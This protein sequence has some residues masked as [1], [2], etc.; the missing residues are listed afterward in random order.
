MDICLKLFLL[1]GLIPAT[2]VLARDPVGAGPKDFAASDADAQIRNL[3]KKI[4]PL[5]PADA[6]K[7]FELADGL[8]MELAASEPEIT[9]PIAMAW[10]EHLN[11]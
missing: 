9:D 8:T 3:L 1:V 2:A 4:E 5:E 11:L 7:T 6:L 10:D